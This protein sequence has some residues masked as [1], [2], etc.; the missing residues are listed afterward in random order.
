MCVGG[1]GR[2]IIDTE[3]QDH[4]S[5]LRVERGD[6]QYKEERGVERQR[7]VGDRWTEEEIMGRWG[8]AGGRRRTLVSG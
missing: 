3:G 7:E 2:G 5:G 1:E 4:V 6:C 8:C